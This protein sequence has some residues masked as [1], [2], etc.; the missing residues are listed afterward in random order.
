[1]P[2]R[3]Y[4]RHGGRFR[5]GSCTGSKSTITKSNTIEQKVLN[6]YKYAIRTMKEAG[7]YN[8]ITTYLILHIR[9]TDKH[10]R[11]I[12]DAV[13]KQE[14]FNFEPS[15]P[16]LRI[17]SIVK[18]VETSPQEKQEIKD[19]KNQYNIECEAEL[20]L[21]L[22]QKCH[23]CTNQGKA[24]AFLFG[25]CTTGLQ[26]RIEA[27]AKYKSKV[28]GD[29]IKL[30]ETI[31]ENSLSFNDKK[32]ANIV[33]FDAIM[34]LMTTRQR[35]DEDLTEYTKC[36]KAVR[37]LCKEKYGGYLKSQCSPRKSPHGALIKK[38]ATRQWMPVSYPS[39]I[40]R[41]WIKQSMVHP[42]RMAEDVATGRENVYPIHIKDAQHILSID[43][44]DD[45]AYH[46]KQKKQ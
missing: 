45:Q 13:E 4:G 33:T 30:L 23:Y 39:C 9:K 14:P 38:P 36:I 21:H 7:N 12:A 31:K 43:H 35:D 42:S 3:M 44:K 16:R 6:D 18:T 17:L 10:G 2:G 26:H 24:Y 40:S 41:I 32:K 20:Q 22:K 29:P 19:E 8:K 5:Q 1:M 28:K 46:D 37:D 34:N 15:A 25:P 27:K 11:D